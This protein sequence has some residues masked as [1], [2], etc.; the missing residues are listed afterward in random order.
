M[1]QR[2]RDYAKDYERIG[3]TVR[4]KGKHYRLTMEQ[5][6][7][8]RRK[9]AYVV[10]LAL[11][12]ALFI[13]IGFSGSPALGARGGAGGGATPIY[14]VLPY[15]ILLLPLGLGLARAFLLAVKSTPLEYA[16]YDKNLVQQKAVLL[17]ALVCS[18]VFL[19]SLLAFLLFGQADATA[20]LPAIAESLLLTG[21]IFLA[22]RQ[23]HALLGSIAI[24]EAKSVRYDI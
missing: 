15:V 1:F 8:N 11:A 14:V 7:Q 4:Y 24:D 13:A 17:S 19:V 2:T 18:C 10:S 20:Q 3:S 5:P 6:A 16:E 9:A 22:F 23:Y 12:F 21:C